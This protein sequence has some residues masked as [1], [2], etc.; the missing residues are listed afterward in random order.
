MDIRDLIKPEHINL[1]LQGATKDEVIREMVHLL[2]ENGIL[3]DRQAFY[4]E[5]IQR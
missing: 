1:N 5:I 2:D 4:H 3:L